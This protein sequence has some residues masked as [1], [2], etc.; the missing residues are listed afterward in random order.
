M[1]DEQAIL[2]ALQ[3]LKQ[4]QAKTR[5]VSLLAR[6]ALELHKI[7][8]EH[9]EILPKVPKNRLLLNIFIVLNGR[10]LRNKFRELGWE[11]RLALLAL[12]DH[13]RDR[14]LAMHDRTPFRLC[15]GGH[16]RA[17]YD[18]ARLILCTP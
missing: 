5:K 17:R 4:E 8:V 2:L 3:E 18:R 13:P 11:F 16:S 1:E 10:S 6:R 12:K 15:R 9:M 7:A 14:V